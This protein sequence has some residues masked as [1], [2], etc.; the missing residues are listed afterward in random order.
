MKHK[1]SK[2]ENILMV[3]KVLAWLAV[4]G[5]IVQ[6]GAI[7]ISYGVSWV[8]PDGARNLYNGLDLYKLRQLNFNYYTSVVSF[9]V[10]LLLLKS[11]VWF[12]VTRTL[13][14]ISL[15]NPFTMD[16]AR[17]L[18]KISYVLMGTWIVGVLSNIYSNW[19][20]KK[21]GQLFESTSV[22]ELFFMAGLV[23]IISQ[24]FKRGVE[25]QSENELTV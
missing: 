12:L 23:F 7:L 9:M 22:D 11:F 3:M 14:K 25:I 20:L 1:H 24:V 8:N 16:V 13:S 4:A 19:L 18:E 15:S 21:T 5:F 10:A 6:A 2:T 17:R